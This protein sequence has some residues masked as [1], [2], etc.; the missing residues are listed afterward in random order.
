MKDPVVFNYLLSAFKR[1]DPNV[2]GM[3]SVEESV[4]A[5]LKVIANL[6]E[7]D[8]GDFVSHHGNKDWL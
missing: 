3:I 7:G 6:D 2:T 8:S 5:Q 1:L 4:S